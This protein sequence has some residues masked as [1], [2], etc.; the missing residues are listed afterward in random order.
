MRVIT[1]DQPSGASVIQ[2][3]CICHDLD[4]LPTDPKAVW[5]YMAQQD[6]TIHVA[7]AGDRPEQLSYIRCHWES[8]RLALLKRTVEDE[9]DRPRLRT[10]VQIAVRLANEGTLPGHRGPRARKTEFL[11]RCE[12]AMQLLVPGPQPKITGAQRREIEAVLAGVKIADPKN[13]L[14]PACGGETTWVMERDGPEKWSRCVR[15]G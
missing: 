8:R 11:R 12:A 1:R 5:V 10:V 4:L 6:A 2:P 3:V 9:Y 15:C 13:C 7:S 14:N